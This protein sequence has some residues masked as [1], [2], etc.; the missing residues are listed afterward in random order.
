MPAGRGCLPTL[1]MTALRVA[2][3]SGHADAT[4][5]IGVEEQSRRSARAGQVGASAAGC[6]ERT[7]TASGADAIVTGVI[8]TCSRS[9]Q[10]Q[11]SFEV[12]TPASSSIGSADL[13]TSAVRSYS[14]GRGG[15]PPTA[16]RGPVSALEIQKMNGGEQRV[17]SAS[18]RS[19][20][21]VNRPP[22]PYTPYCGCLQVFRAHSGASVNARKTPTLPC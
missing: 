15:P 3:R 13:A 8:S 11:L 14:G 16:R 9:T 12:I 20:T 10:R 2:E 6:R 22:R 21:T 17:H 19:T 1:S 5:A 7:A 4:T 18:T